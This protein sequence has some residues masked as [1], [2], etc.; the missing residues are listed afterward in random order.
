[1]SESLEEI[2]SPMPGEGSHF[3]GDLDIATMLVT[4][5]RGLL[6]A[7][8]TDAVRSAAGSASVGVLATFFDVIASTPTLAACRPDWTATQSLSLHAT[9]W[10][11]E[12]PIVVD[13]SLVRV[14]KKVVV[15]EAEIWDGHGF[16]D[17]TELL[18]AFGAQG[19]DAPAPGRPEAS[20]PGAGR[21][22]DPTLAARGLLT[23]ARLPGTAGGAFAE[24]YDPKNS[25]GKVQRPAGDPP[26]GGTVW[27]RIGLQVIDAPGGVTELERVPYITNSIGT[28]NGGALAVMVERAAEVMRPGLVATDVQLQYLSQVKVGP[29]RTRGVVSRDAADHSVVTIEILDHGA[30]DQILALATVTLQ[31]PP[32]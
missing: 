7:P 14:G 17:T 25:I 20:R 6:W 27:E 16:D 26:V 2:V 10:L 18:G 19:D 5:E 23:F 13:V 24:G 29:A 1:M 8:L 12:G 3:V 15:V 22:G 4:L 28:I 9:G 32:G 30:D 31:P 21:P 11:V